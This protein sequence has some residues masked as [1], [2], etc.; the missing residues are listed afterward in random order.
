MGRDIGRFLCTAGA[1]SLFLCSPVYAQLCSL[2][3]R[4]VDAE[5]GEAMEFANV[6]LANTTSGTSTDARG[7]FALSGIPAGD[8]DIVVSRV[9]YERTTKQI[10]L[11]PDANPGFGFEIDRKELRADEVEVVAPDPS[12][13][14]RLLEQFTKEFLG[15]TPNASQ[16][17]ILNPYHLDL[18]FKE[19]SQ[20][21]TARCDTMLLVENNA[22]AYRIADFL[23]CTDLCGLALKMRNSCWLSLL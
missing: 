2:H 11:T 21:L 13:W 9:G 6:F 7:L 5:S 14:R 19:D 22:L 4:V 3:G 17:R 15:E 8:Y 18:Q 20:T 10:S 1:V 16:C 23:P 12:K